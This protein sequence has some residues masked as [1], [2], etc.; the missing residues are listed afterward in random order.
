MTD[1]LW[2]DEGAGLGYDIPGEAKPR[3]TPKE[4]Q[5][6]EAIVVR[7]E[8]MRDLEEQVRSRGP[9]KVELMDDPY[10]L[11]IGFYVPK[12]NEWFQI[13]LIDAKARGGFDVEA[14]GSEAGRQAL[15]ESLAR[16]PRKWYLEEI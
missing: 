12:T 7:C 16:G 2:Y 8:S 4:W 13:R 15:A 11:I 6:S 10:K 9:T 3:P 5:S 1:V 14:H